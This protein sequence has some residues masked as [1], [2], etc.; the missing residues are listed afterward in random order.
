MSHQL[1]QFFPVLLCASLLLMLPG[2]ASADRTN[3]PTAIAQKQVSS[4]RPQKPIPAQVINAVRQDLAKITKIAAGKFKVK[5]SSPQT[6]QDG[7]LGLAAPNE[8]CTMALIDGWQVVM[9]YGKQTW[10]YRT[11][12]SGRAVRLEKF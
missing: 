2:T 5:E 6:W 12:S 11:D 8:F 1:P 3:S 9:T 4:Q 7:C 10:T